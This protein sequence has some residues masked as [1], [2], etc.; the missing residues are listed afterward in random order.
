MHQSRK[1]QN[2]AFQF[3][4][5]LSTLASF[6]LGKFEEYQK[7]IKLERVSNLSFQA[8]CFQHQTF[9]H[10]TSSYVGKSLLRCSICDTLY[11]EVKTFNLSLYMVPSGFV[12]L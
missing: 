7:W 4:E 1:R 12:N 5:N 9:L 10:I 8:I 3:I 6:I 2:F 11:M